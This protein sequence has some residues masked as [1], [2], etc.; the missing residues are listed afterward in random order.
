[1]RFADWGKG[2]S[3]RWRGNYWARLLLSFLLIVL[4]LL[5]LLPGS[6][7]AAPTISPLT[8][9]SGQVGV[10]Y[11]Q[12]LTASGTPPYT[13]TPGA[14]PPGLTFASSGNTATI[15]GTPTTAGS[16]TF[17]LTV[18]DAG[19][20][21]PVGY[22]ITIAAKPLDFLYDY[23]SDA[24]EGDS[25][26]G[27]TGATGGTTPYT[28]SLISGSLPSGL[29]L[30][31]TSGLI[32]GTPAKGMAGTYYF[33]IRVTDSS[34]SPLYKDQSYTL[35]VEKGFYDSVITIASTLAAGEANVYVDGKQVA[36]LGGGQTT[37]QS[38]AMGTE[39]DITVDP[40]VSHPTRTDVRFVADT[41]Q[42][43]VD[44]L[45][46]DVT[47]TYHPEYFVDLKTDPS[48]IASLTGSNW[49]KEGVTLRS[50]ASAQIEGK[51]GA[52]YR[53]SYWLLPTG[54]KS[55]DEDLSW[56]VTAPGKAIATYDTY[57]Q[58]TVISPQSKVTGSGWY[59]AGTAAQWSLNP[60]EV[61]MSGIF[62]LFLGK[63]KPDSATGTEVMD[64]PKTV[65]VTWHPDYTMPAVLLSLLFI[66][67]IA[68]IFGV[69]RLLYPPPKPAVAPTPPAPAPPTIVVVG[70]AQK[71]DLETTREQLVEK[72]SEIL[73]KYENEVKAAIK[74]ELPEAKLIPESQRL[75]P[76][77]RKTT[78]GHISKNLIRTVAGNWRK[79]EEKIQ[80]KTSPK[81]KTAE[82]GISLVTVWA[83]D[84]YN[85][86]G[87][88]TCSLPSGHSSG[89]KGTTRIAYSL[90]NTITEERTYGAKEKVTPPK[91]H[92]TDELPV[93]DIARHEV[94][95]EESASTNDVDTPYDVIPPEEQ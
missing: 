57:Y 83:R 51:T 10:A 78:C 3:L 12:I 13:W 71:P 37:R 40:V 28:F 41:T 26:Q 46:P 56:I 81:R 50:T 86:W 17:L 64:A 68:V 61:S 90:Q 54:E 84:I 87:I 1:V 88:S 74:P 31:S 6:A 43:T 27:Y 48:Q 45:S 80:T 91:P 32:S 63:L 33:T 67:L 7:Q 23:L 35:V 53:F 5:F 94:I 21:I 60:P 14:L 77:K 55:T 92:F 30:N 66:F 76:P 38:F 20:P 22:T 29:S 44:E 89:H 52:Q 47:F 8:L 34:S 2:Y 69:R 25:Y 70:G 11:L 65:T 72:F 18:T 73:Q 93:V 85:E 59:K 75:A 79:A 42:V 4:S 16:Y 36:K 95:A 58:L 19:G 15:S 24:T 9:P 82:K 49:Y 39:P 62:G